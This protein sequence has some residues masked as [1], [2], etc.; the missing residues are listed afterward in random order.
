MLLLYGNND[1]QGKEANHK[2]LHLL[3]ENAVWRKLALFRYPV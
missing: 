1:E 3:L 2:E